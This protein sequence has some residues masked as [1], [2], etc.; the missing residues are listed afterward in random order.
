MCDRWADTPSNLAIES[1]MI[2][3][4]VNESIRPWKLRLNLVHRND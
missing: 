2:R 3:V 4:G 1:H